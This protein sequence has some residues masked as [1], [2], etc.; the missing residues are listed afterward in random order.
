MSKRSITPEEALNL[1]LA[2]LRFHRTT[3]AERWIRGLQKIMVEQDKKD[4]ETG[5]YDDPKDAVDEID[6]SLAEQRVSDPGAVELLTKRVLQLT[7]A[8]G[9]SDTY[10]VA[11]DMTKLVVHASKTMPT[12]T[13]ARIDVPSPLGF[14]IFD[15]GLGD[16]WDNVP[17]VPEDEGIVDGSEQCVIGAISWVALD[18]KGVIVTLY[19]DESFGGGF[20]TARYTYYTDFQW[21]YE[22]SIVNPRDHW[23]TGD[24]DVFANIFTFWTLIQQ[25]IGL[26]QKVQM[27]RAARRRAEREMAFPPEFGEI[28]V[29]ALR[30]VNRHS[31]DDR[32]SDSEEVDWSHRWIVGGHWRNQWYPSISD[33]RQIWINP[34]IKGP[35]D[36]PFVPR[37][38]VWD[39]RQ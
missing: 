9:V 25:R 1:Q 33:H 32:D 20:A 18:E 19:R 4:L 17:L 3:L 29:I 36:K 38:T 27:S 37:D 34:Y 30:R 31:F 8:L 6:K 23:P 16:F 10:L 21:W 15:G 12:R 39:F 13:L 2:T 11:E 14:A 5:I 7:E 28:R 24:E 22:H 26:P 35:D